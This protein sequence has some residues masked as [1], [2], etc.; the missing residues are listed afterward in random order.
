MKQ[1]AHSAA[2]FVTGAARGRSEARSPVIALLFQGGIMRPPV[3]G[4]KPG[5][6]RR[7][8][9]RHGKAPQR[10]QNP[11]EKASQGFPGLPSGR[12]NCRP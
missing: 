4:S 5:R 1:Y 12:R 10:R 2:F 8:Y 7:Q 11:F 6:G 9:R 3:E